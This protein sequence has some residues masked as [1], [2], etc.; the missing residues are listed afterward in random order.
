MQHKNLLKRWLQ[1]NEII[2]L[3]Q[4]DDTI[5]L[6]RA[7]IIIFSSLWRPFIFLGIVLIFFV[8]ISSLKEFSRDWRGKHE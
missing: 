1:S 3:S 6:E 4:G 7:L 5:F 8:P 2:L